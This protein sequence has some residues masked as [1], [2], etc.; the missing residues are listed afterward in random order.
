MSSHYNNFTSS[1]SSS[2]TTPMLTSSTKI[3][4]SPTSLITSHT[5]GTMSVT[6]AASFAQTATS[7]AT[8]ESASDG[9]LSTGA[10][11]GI[12]VGVS[13]IGLAAIGGCGALIWHRRRKSSTSR[14]I[15]YELDENPKS[16]ARQSI[17]WG[18]TEGKWPTQHSSN[19]PSELPEQHRA[20]LS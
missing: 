1:A 14:D 6:S 10:E 8:R 7:T 12:G 17:I 19:I 4:V 15:A 13:L 11:A 9:G 2:S 3:S 20:E 16:E 18:S 5:S